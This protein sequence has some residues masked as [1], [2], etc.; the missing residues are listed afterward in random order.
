MSGSGPSE[1]ILRRVAEADPDAIAAIYESYSD[2]V[3]LTALRLLGNHADAEDTLQDLFLGLPQ[4]VANFARKGSF[5]GWLRGVTRNMCLMVL[6]RQRLRKEAHFN[7]E[8]IACIPHREESVIDALSLEYALLSLPDSQRVVY[9]LKQIEGHSHPE[10][11]EMLSITR[12]ASRSRYLR[13]KKH[14]RMALGG[15]R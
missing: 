8:V 10:I 4:A 5:E 2:A 15:E 11:A 3:Y 7:D 12:Y 9:V 6:R 14:L 13:A 1:G